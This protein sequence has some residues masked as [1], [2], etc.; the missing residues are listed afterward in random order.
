MATH[1]PL[2]IVNGQVQ[3]LPS[4]DTVDPAYVGSSAGMTWT[5]VTSANVA[6]AVTNTG[7]LMRTGGTL[8]TVTLPAACPAGFYCSVNADGG[9]VRIVSNGNII[10]QVGSG[11]DLL[12]DANSTVTLVAAATG[13]LEILY[14]IQAPTSITR[15]ISIVSSATPAGSALYTDYVYICSGT[16][17]LT[18]PT[19]VGN[20]NLYTVKNTGTGVISIATTSSETI[21]GTTAPITINVQ[22]ESLNLI[23][24]GS[25]WRIV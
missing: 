6:T 7:Y 2:V 25:N 19:A 21:D 20:T 18:L 24:D 1:V 5:P 16:M 12:M 14:G 15:S 9:Q 3:R 4:G 22:D 8:R 11:N 10:D 17:T 13:T 23:S